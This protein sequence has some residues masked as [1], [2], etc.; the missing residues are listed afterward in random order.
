[1]PNWEEKFAVWSRGPSEAERNRLDRVVKDISDTLRNDE[2]LK[3]RNL[4]IFAQGSYRNRVNVRKDSDVDICALHD[5]VFFWNVPDGKNI[6]D[7]VD[8]FYEA[9]YKYEEYKQDV[10]NALVKRYGRSNVRRGN[11]AI[12]VNNRYLDIDA[13]VVATFEYR[14]YNRDNLFGG[15]VFGT[16]LRS[17][18]GEFCTNFPQQQYDNGVSKHDATNRRFKRQVRIQKNLRNEMTEAGSLSAEAMKS[19]LIESL[20]W[21][22]PNPLYGNGQYFSDFENVMRWI[23][24]ETETDAQASGLLEVNG[25]KR[26]IDSHNPWTRQM[27]RSFV[28]E[29]W[30][31][32]H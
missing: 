10:E 31:L 21:N 20:C 24:R 5:N 13:D 32:T 11:K 17:D 15:P 19:F 27:I 2:K 22:A 8:P 7:Y 14:D 28:E 16:A 3:S 26:L 29:A 9:S 1:M 23:H 12:D 25:I 18:K 30:T 4:E 6:G